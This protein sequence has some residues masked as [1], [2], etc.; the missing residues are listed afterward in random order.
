M[1]TVIFFGCELGKN[2]GS[3]HYLMYG[4][5]TTGGILFVGD[6]K[7]EAFFTSQ[8]DEY[9]SHV[10]TRE[11]NGNQEKA[12]DFLLLSI[13]EEETRKM[14]ATCEACVKAHKP[15]NLS[16][17]LLIHIPFREPEEISVF[18]AQTLN[19]TQAVILILREC[20]NR[21]NPL[22]K[23]LEGLK[24][25]QTFMDVLYDRLKPYTLPVSWTSLINLLAT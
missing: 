19:S 20:L 18:A 10:F 7:I 22:L 5:Y 15:F 4:K 3:L 6:T 13:D 24:S 21:D 16:D 8:N 17:M 14:R 1:K 23:G 2:E 11:K 12:E 25:R 9:R